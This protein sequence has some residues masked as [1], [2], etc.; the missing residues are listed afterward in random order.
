MSAEQ[1][2][3]VDVRSLVRAVEL[4]SENSARSPSSPKEE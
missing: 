2:R 4:D 1:P 3:G